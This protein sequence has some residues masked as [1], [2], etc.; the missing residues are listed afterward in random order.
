MSICNTFSAFSSTRS[1]HA[2]VLYEAAMRR[3]FF[4][5]FFEG[6]L[7]LSRATLGF[8]RAVEGDGIAEKNWKFGDCAELVVV[9]NRLHHLY[10]NIYFKKHF[11]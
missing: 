6:G 9:R 4:G 8:F 5:F 2:G 7:P 1:T 10:R 3:T 11:N